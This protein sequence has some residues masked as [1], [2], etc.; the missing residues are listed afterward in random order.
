MQAL[1]RGS[2]QY[3]FGRPSLRSVHGWRLTFR[4]R[5]LL[6]LRGKGTLQSLTPHRDVKLWVDKEAFP[7]VFSLLQKAE[8]TIV[9]QMFIWRD[10]E[11]GQRMATVLL[12]AANRGVRVDITKEA[13]GDVFEVHRDFLS[14][15]NQAQP[16]WQRFWKHP[17]IRIHYATN[18][19]HAKVYIIDGKILLLT[20]MNIADEYHYILHD[21]LVELRGNRFVERYLTRGELPDGG[22]RVQIKMN[23]EV[24]KEIRPVVM[25]LLAGAKKSIVIE[26]CYLSDPAV[27]QLLIK[28]S[29][30]GVRVTI[31]TP[32]KMEFVHHF[33]SMEAMSELVTKGSPKFLKVFLF[34]GEFHAKILLVDHVKAFI[35][36]ANLMTSSLDEMGEVNVLLQGNRQLALIK[37]RDIL[38]A[39]ILKSKLM[40]SPSRMRWAVRWL[41]WLKL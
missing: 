27:I 32:E 2:L 41:A 7:R 33:S 29:K 23:N 22:S 12:E 18:N 19:D 37:L 25:Q 26:H 31:I 10:D 1:Y 24:V 38:R 36:S 30:D 11:I 8:H 39:D 3:L 13:I 15:K 16:L 14:T 9:I 34:P 21:Y 20:G 4:L 40:T 6:L 5:T 17:N 28:R 35:G